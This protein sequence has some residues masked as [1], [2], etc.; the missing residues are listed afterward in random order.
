MDISGY[1]MEFTLKLKKDKYE[2]EEAEISRICAILQAIALL[3]RKEQCLMP[4]NICIQDK[5]Q[6]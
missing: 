1:G 4:M 5:R 6:V 2:D 3:L